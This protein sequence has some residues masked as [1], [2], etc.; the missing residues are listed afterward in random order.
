VVL[1]YPALASPVIAR[2]ESLRRTAHFAAAADAAVGEAAT[3]A[4]RDAAMHE[5]RKAAKRAQYVLETA[6]P[7]LGKQAR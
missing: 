3:D 6:Q 4:D 2:T 1:T 7:A 5:M